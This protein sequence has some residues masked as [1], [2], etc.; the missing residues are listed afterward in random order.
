MKLKKY[1]ILV[2]IRF[3]EQEGGEIYKFVR[4]LYGTIR[5]KL[6]FKGLVT[7]KYEEE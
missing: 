1:K 5:E 2:V 6:D 4:K 7:I 3:E